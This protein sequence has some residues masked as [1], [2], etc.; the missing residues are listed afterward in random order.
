NQK[1]AR[2][3]FGR[4]PARRADDDWLK[5]DFIGARSSPVVGSGTNNFNHVM[6]RSTRASQAGMKKPRYVRP[7]RAIN[8]CIRP[9]PVVNSLSLA[10]LLNTLPRHENAGPISDRN[11]EHDLAFGVTFLDILLR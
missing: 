3:R 6:A 4:E 10:D 9:D 8:S 5:P 7:N 11:L 2:R 1:T